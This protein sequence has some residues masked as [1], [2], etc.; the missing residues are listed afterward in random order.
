MTRRI[1]IPLLLDLLTVDDPQHI[2]AL[3]A[4]P[5]VGRS[6]ALSSSRLVRWLGGRLR[7]LLSVAN[8]PY[9][10]LLPREDKIRAAQTAM[11]E[12]RL[13]AR[14]EG[15]AIP[16]ETVRLL[17]RY[18]RGETAE[19]AIL[20]PLQQLIGG[21][22]VGAYDATDEA[23]ADALRLGGAARNPLRG[24]WLWLT[25]R[26]GPLQRRISRACDGD[27]Y[28]AHGTVVGFQSVLIELRKLRAHCIETGGAAGQG[29]KAVVA[30]V[31]APPPKTLRAATGKV[32][33]DF[34]DAPVGPGTLIILAPSAKGPEAAFALGRWSQ[35]PAHGFV[36]RLL[37]ESWQAATGAAAAP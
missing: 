5:A 21:Q 7:R 10:A 12:A 20:V 16:A 1:R 23:V 30:S 33:A 6:F 4:H 25:R 2:A 29:A 28:A 9:P 31:I 13:G 27:I 3:D 8:T 19:A 14:G 15:V 18:V 34:L 32:E 24:L 26:L 35:C 17:G 37:E 11:L 36:T 22:M